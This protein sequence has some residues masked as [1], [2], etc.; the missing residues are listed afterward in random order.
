M[1]WMAPGVATWFDV[2]GDFSYF[3][4][5][6]KDVLFYEFSDIM[7]SGNRDIRIDL[8]MSV[9]QHMSPS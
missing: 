6:L 1:I 7:T 4:Q 8:N 9:G 2:N 3:G 5:L